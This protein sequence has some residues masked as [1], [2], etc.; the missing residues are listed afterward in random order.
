MK[1]FIIGFIV[2]ILVALVSQSI[3]D[4]H[5]VGS[6]YETIIIGGIA[7]LSGDAAGYG[8]MAQNV[9]N[10]FVK[11]INELGGVNGR[12]LEIIWEDDKC[13]PGDASRA[14]QKLIGIDKISVILGSVCSGATLG[15]APITEKNEVI[16]MA[17]LASS[18]EITNAGD[19]VFRTFPSDSSQGKILAERANTLFH[20]VGILAEQ[21]DYALGVA[22]VFEE[23]FIGE[24]QREEFLSSES[25]FKTRITKLKNSDIEALFLSTQ[26]PPKMDIIL[27][28]LAEQNWNIPIWGNEMLANDRDVVTKHAYFL[29]S[30]DSAFS[31]ILSPP[32]NEKFHDFVARYKNSFGENP[33][34]MDYAGPAA[35]GINVLAHVLGKV[36][37][38]TDTKAIRD[39]LYELND[40]EGMHGPLTF[41]ENGDV[42]L[43]HTL[44]QFD[45]KKFSP[46]K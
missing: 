42:G 11:E 7:A 22:N 16:L 10:L 20:K 36:D 43:T 29:K 24:T 17:T 46:A 35:D 34:F 26:G 21:S 38:I 39:A 13:T 33:K 18:P 15:A 37:D 45:G 44:L 8:Q 23:Y 27:K 6:D 30:L 25:D 5:D 19:F 12:L 14:V 40:F 32:D 4:N 41:D 28:Q 1:K 31:A 3:D 2:G 9:A